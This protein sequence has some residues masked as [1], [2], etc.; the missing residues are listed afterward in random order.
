MLVCRHPGLFFPLHPAGQNF[1]NHCEKEKIA[2]TFIYLTWFSSSSLPAN[3]CVYFFCNV[4]ATIRNFTELK[5]IFL[6]YIIVQSAV[7]LCH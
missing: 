3:S 4:H 7:T 1:F 5:N 6:A 2:L